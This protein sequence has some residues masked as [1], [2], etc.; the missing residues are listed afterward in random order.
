M[1]LSTGEC[2]ISQSFDG[3]TTVESTRQKEITNDAEKETRR[4]KLARRS[5]RTL[6]ALVIIACLISLAVLSLTILNMFGKIGDGRLC[7]ANDGQSTTL[8]YTFWGRGGGEGG[9]C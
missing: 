9:I 6:L 3:W 7:A 4:A 5:N 8:G 1:S 2:V